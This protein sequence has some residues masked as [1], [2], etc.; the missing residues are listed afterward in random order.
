[1]KDFHGNSQA[2]Q[3]QSAFSLIWIQIHMTFK[4]EQ[5]KFWWG[6]CLC[7]SCEQLNHLDV[8]TDIQ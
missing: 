5:D 6:C 8:S 1:M 3:V 7:G 4:M 2:E